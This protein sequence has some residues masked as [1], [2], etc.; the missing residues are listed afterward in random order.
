[1]KQFRLIQ[2]KRTRQKYIALDAEGLG[3]SQLIRTVAG[4]YDEVA[5]DLEVRKR[6]RYSL[7]IEGDFVCFAVK[8]APNE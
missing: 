5:E 3:D 4:L 7:P 6:L 1:M 8:P 2:N